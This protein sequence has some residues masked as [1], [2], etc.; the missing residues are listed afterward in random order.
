MTPVQRLYHIDH[1]QWYDRFRKCWTR[2]IEKNLELDLLCALNKSITSQTK[3]IEIGC[4]TGINIAR[5]LL[6]RKKFRS[7][8]GIDFSED[9]LA[10]AQKKF[11]V[12]KKISFLAADA[13]CVE[14]VE[15]VARATDRRRLSLSAFRGT[16][17]PT[18]GLGAGLL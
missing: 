16:L 6:L 1:A 15:S 12:Q 10:I 4:G 9:M 8:L 17:E 13:R 7:Y 2:I 5:I 3:I 11:T 18:C 14:Q